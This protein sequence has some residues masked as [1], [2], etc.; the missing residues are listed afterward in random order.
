MNIECMIHTY[1][2][3]TPPLIPSISLIIF[4]LSGKRRKSHYRSKRRREVLRSVLLVA[5]HQ[6]HH[7]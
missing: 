4:M 5:L 6:S 1:I 3:H 7:R 2:L